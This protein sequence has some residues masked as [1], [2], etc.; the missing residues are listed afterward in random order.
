MFVLKSFELVLRHRGVHCG[1]FGLQPKSGSNSKNSKSSDMAEPYGCLIFTGQPGAC[2]PIDKILN[3]LF[4]SL[5]A[6]SMTMRPR[7]DAGYCSG[8]LGWPTPQT[9]H[10][11]LSAPNSTFPQHKPKTIDQVSTQKINKS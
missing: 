1:G 11:V 3:N 6:V 8:T 5:H 9:A 2:G 4:Q 7:N 10:T